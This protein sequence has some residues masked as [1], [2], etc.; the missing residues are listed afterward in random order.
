[1]TI[2]AS[3]RRA[4]PFTGTGQAVDYPFTFKI[5]SPEHVRVYVADQ[6][7]SERELNYPAEY[8]VAPNP[9]QETHP[10]GM[11]RL[12]TPL[13]QGKT[14]TLISRMD[15]QQGT[16]FTNQGGFYPQVLNDALDILTIYIQQ[17]DEV[18][19]R[20]LTGSVNS[21]KSPTFPAGEAGKFLRWDAQGESLINGELDM[22]RIQQDLQ[23]MK[24]QIAALGGAGAQQILD[25]MTQIEQTFVSIENTMQQI[26]SANQA[27]Q[28]D[29][30]RYKVL[31]FA[32]V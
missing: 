16:E 21:G 27:I 4:G 17:I 12:V 5:F 30:T 18:L 11:V 23:E 29:F 10:G 6:N 28:G 32:G 31:I 8:T 7:G 3:T 19:K 9:H 14:A 25:R 2:A 24:G 13:A 1:M 26:Q 22:D 15:I 20:T